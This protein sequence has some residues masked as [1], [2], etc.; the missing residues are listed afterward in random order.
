[1]VFK[2]PVRNASNGNQAMTQ[3]VIALRLASADWRILT[4][5]FG[6]PGIPNT[7]V[8]QTGLYYNNIHY[9]PLSRY[10][11]LSCEY[12]LTGLSTFMSIDWD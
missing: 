1:M 2:D 8:L 9:I 5:N 6:I 12:E 3:L 4:D 10:Q 11:S 7:H